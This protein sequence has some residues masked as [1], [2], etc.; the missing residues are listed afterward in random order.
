MKRET[1]RTLTVSV[2]FMICSCMFLMF[3]MFVNELSFFSHSPILFVDPRAL[4]INQVRAAVKKKCS[5]VS[6]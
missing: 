1:I 4:D 2:K 5:V 3:L 6:V